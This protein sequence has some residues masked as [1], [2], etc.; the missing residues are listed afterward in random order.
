MLRN[1]YL[2]HSP[3]ELAKLCPR[4]VQLYLG[5]QGRLL[6]GGDIGAGHIQ[7]DRAERTFQ[8]EENR[9]CVTAWQAGGPLGSAWLERGQRYRA[10]GVGRC[11]WIEGPGIVDEVPYVPGH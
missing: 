11:S 4:N 3:S 10:R 8:A 5:D 6:G 9:V 2:Q 7:R 1:R